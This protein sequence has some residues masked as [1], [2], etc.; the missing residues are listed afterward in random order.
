[1]C[2]TFILLVNMTDV[3]LHLSCSKEHRNSSL[4]GKVGFHISSDNAVR[5]RTE[6]FFLALNFPVTN[7]QLQAFEFYLPVNASQPVLFSDRLTAR[8]SSITFSSARRR[9]VFK[10]YLCQV[11]PF[12]PPQWSAVIA[13]PASMERVPPIERFHHF[14]GYGTLM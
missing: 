11:A 14:E 3:G 4:K 12:I 8:V 7:S 10:C 5:S 6:R 1:M 9:E 13:P 2:I